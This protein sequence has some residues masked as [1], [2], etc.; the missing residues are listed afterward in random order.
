MLLFIK[1]IMLYLSDTTLHNEEVRIVHIELNTMKQILNL[2]LLRS[3]TINHILILAT[4]NNLK[5][6]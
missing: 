3:V 2:A 1:Y 5:C 4:N 6:K